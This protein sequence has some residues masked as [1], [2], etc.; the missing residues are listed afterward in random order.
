MAAVSKRS[1]G[2]PQV[3]KMWWLS[4][5]LSTVVVGVVAALLQQIISTARQIDEHAAAIWTVGKDIAANTV[6]IWILS[7]TNDQ[8]GRTL[9]AVQGV[10][11][12]VTSID[13]KVRAL[14]ATDGQRG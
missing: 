9:E 4:L 12:A 7:K 3:I 8:V 10:D 11:R 14:A 2:S 13:E 5:G 1:S 6:S